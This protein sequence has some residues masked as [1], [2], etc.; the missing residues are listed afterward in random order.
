MS[1]VAALISDLDDHGFE[2]TDAD[3]KV[4]VINDTIA[5]I[6]SREPWPFLE[7][8]ASVTCN[9][10]APALP[11]DFR[12][13]LAVI[14]PSNGVVLQPERLDTIVKRYPNALTSQG[15]PAYYYFIGSQINLVP[16][17]DQSYVAQLYYLRTHPFVTQSSGETDILIPA[18][19]HRAI[20]LG[21][22]ARLYAM[23][24]DPDLATVFNQLYEQRLVTMQADL[25]QRQF[26]RTDRVVDLW[27]GDDYDS[28]G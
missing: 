14:I 23:E 26:D 7:S 11:S 21:T 15:T 12:A 25:W 19:H 17:P 18:R 6:C 9:S 13:S 27:D 20:V 28:F 22:L 10:Q 8:V 5:D 1:S 2:D 4:A 16:V 24:D 3:R